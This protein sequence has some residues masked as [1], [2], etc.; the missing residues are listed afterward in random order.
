MSRGP[1]AVLGA[2][3]TT[4]RRVVAA[5]RRRGLPVVA[6]SRHP[7]PTGDPGVVARHAEL[8][9]PATVRRA[10]EGASAAYLI[11]PTF[12]GDETRLLADA[13][14]SCQQAGVDRVVLHSVLHPHTPT[15]AH[16]L[17]KADAE[18]ALRRTDAAWTVLQPAMYV[19]TVT[20]ALARGTTADGVVPV[21]W[22]VTTALTPVHLGDVAEVA[23]RVLD[24]PGHEHASYE[25]AGPQALSAEQ[26][27]AQIAEVTGRDLRARQVDVHDVLPYP[28][29]SVEAETLVAMCEEYGRHGLLGNPRVL[30]ML[31][32]RAPTRFADACRQDLATLAPTTPTEHREGTP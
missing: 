4:G 11:P 27:V 3:G 26:M 1:V 29:G 5:L 2:S 8:R 23:A 14:T 22:D 6:L 9:E 24:E 12:Q 16:H 17:R 13:A 31:L 32:G 21:P 19:Q 7:A 28:A 18:D 10:L 30:E 15:M 25:L 20:Q